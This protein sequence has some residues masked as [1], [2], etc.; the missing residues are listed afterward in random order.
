MKRLSFLIAMMILPVAIDAQDVLN[1]E[2][3]RKLAL[4]HNQKVKIAQS[5]IDAADDAKKAAFAQYLP[6]FSV[7]GAY[8]YTNRDYQLLSKDMFL[9]VV[10]Y[11]A[12]D[13][14]TGKLSSAVYTDPSVAASTFVINPS[15][16]TVV[17]DA[18]G[19]PVFQKYSYLPASETKIDM[20]NIY[21]FNGGFSQPIFM[22][23][24]IREANRIAKYTKEIAEQNLS[25]TQNELIYS[26]EEAY[27]RIV[28]LKEKVKMAKEYQTLLNRLV[29]D[30]E[31]IHNEG[32]ITNND[33]LKA[34]VKLSESELMLLK[35]QNGLELSKMVLCQMI[36]VS[37]SS[38]FEVSDSLNSIDSNILSY[39]VND[40]A[41][42]DRPELKILEKNVDVA[43]SGV[44]LMLSR[45]MPNIVMNAGYTY[46]NPNPFNGFEKE[47]GGALTAGVV[48]NIPIFH[49]GDKHNTLAAARKE[50]EAADLK[51]Q[52]ARELL[53]L[54]LQQAVYQYTES[55]KKCE[56]AQLALDQ[57]KQN[58]DYTKDNFGEGILKTTDML[59][60]QAL[61]QKA[62]S[63]LIDA[64]TEQQMS[65]CNLK[66]VTGKN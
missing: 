38:A 35:A 66:K 24:K 1:L 5:Q 33:L 6:D 12:I 57:A 54:Q 26:T 36:G 47:F 39:M 3:C 22:G 21:I 2:Q 64:K 63:D 43:R 16:G 61:W 40:D 49:F 13:Q 56:Y 58:L 62:W 55:V 27:W 34:K 42:A 14:T 10:P 60:A 11:T 4:E 17:T 20:K 28:S 19:N 46:S 48:A 25:L 65:V 50:Q 45:Y 53:V 7:N 44:N 15:T 31:G 52:E 23:G 9:P 32:I 18:S 51:V 59:E 30:L 41:I 8:T 37:Y 29:S